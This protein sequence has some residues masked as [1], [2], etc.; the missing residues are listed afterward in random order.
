VR[1]RRQGAQNQQPRVLLQYRQHRHPHALL[2][3]DG[4]LECGRFGDRQPHPQADQ[5]QHCAGQE[6]DAPAP[7]EEVR[8]GLEMRQ[9]KKNA[10]RADEAQRRAQL[11]EHPVQT[12]LALGCVLG[13]QQHRPAPFAT[14]SK[15]LTKAT[16]RQQ[17]R[18]PDPDAGVCRQQPD[19]NGRQ[20][21]RQQGRDQRRF[22]TNAVTVMPEHR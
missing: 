1:C 3:F 19:R 8:F 13:R 17:R 10:G 16:Q 11:R 14:Q 9:Q 15:T 2:A 12:A 20:A 4:L 21:H 6:R 5:Y 22:A 7:R 18:C